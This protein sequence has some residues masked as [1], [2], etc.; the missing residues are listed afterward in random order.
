MTLSIVIT[1]GCVEAIFRWHTHRRF[2]RKFPKSTGDLVAIRGAQVFAF[3]PH[4]SGELPGGVDPKR[5]FPYRTNGHGLRDRDRP[6]KQPGTRRVLVLGDSYTWGY[7]VA[8]EE[9]FPQAAERLLKARG[10]ADIEVVNGAVPDYNSR[11][12]RQLLAQLLPIYQPDAVFLAYVV[13]DAEPCTAMPVPPE[14]T[15][16]H[17]RSWFVTEA[18]VLLNRHVFRRRLLPTAKDDAGSNYL[19]GFEEDSLKWRDSREAIREMRDLSAAAGIP[20][21]VMILPDVTQNFDDYAWRPIHDAVARW[22]RELNLPTFD[23][24]DDFRGRDHQTLLVPWDGHPN[25]H[26]HEEIATSLVARIL[27]QLS[28]GNSRTPPVHD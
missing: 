28:A 9:A 12:Q 4:A 25:A 16:R 26:A 27:Q 13:N 24:L 14:E 20:F 5:T 3:K 23:L 8:E 17:A 18:A 7:A 2:E 15:Y 1:L 22:G 6:A 11:Q 19:E 10:R 21:T